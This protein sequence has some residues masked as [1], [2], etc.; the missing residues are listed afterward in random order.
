MNT[1]DTP[2]TQDDVAALALAADMLAQVRIILRGINPD[3]HAAMGYVNN[4]AAAMGAPEAHVTA[5]LRRL[6]PSRRT[7]A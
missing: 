3:D 2:T 5:A 4:A 6:D 7:Q 1:A